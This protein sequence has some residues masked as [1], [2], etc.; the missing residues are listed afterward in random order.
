MRV[1]RPRRPEG[2]AN[3][4]NNLRGAVQF[5]SRGNESS[6]LNGAKFDPGLHWNK[7]QSQLSLREKTRVPA[8][9]N[10]VQPRYPNSGQS[11]EADNADTGGEAANKS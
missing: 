4:G 3:I 5:Q 9:S 1:I 6:G 2:A 8:G 7:I 10:S 11:N